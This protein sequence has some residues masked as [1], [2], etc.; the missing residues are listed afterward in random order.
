MTS[1]C[2]EEASFPDL[3]GKVAIITGKVTI[4]SRHRASK[5]QI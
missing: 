3:T 4:Q 5:N 2:I 1:L